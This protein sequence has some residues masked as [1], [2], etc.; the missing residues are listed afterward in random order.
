MIMIIRFG[1]RLHIDVVFG[2]VVD[3]YLGR[4]NGH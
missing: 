2:F 4:Q 1:F 3:K